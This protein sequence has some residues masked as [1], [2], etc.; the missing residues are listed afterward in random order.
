MDF[1]KKISEV[2]EELRYEFV[3]NPLYRG[4]DLDFET[5]FMMKTGLSRETFNDLNKL[6]NKV[7]DGSTNGF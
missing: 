3:I 2:F 1:I 6:S 4:M 5:L 7:N